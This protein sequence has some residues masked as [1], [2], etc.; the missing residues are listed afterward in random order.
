VRLN[1]GRVPAKML[2]AP[3][4]AR[5]IEEHP[6]INL[7][8][9]VDDSGS[10]IVSGRFDAG[11][12]I[13]SQVEQDMIAVRLT[14]EF[15]LVV[16]A[17]PAFLR[18]H[19]RPAEPG[20]V[21]NLPAIR[22]RLP[23][24]GTVHRWLFERGETRLKVA[25][26]GPL[27]VND[28]SLAVRAAVDGVGMIFLPEEW[29]QPYV[30]DSRLVTLLDDWAPRVPGFYLYYASSRQVPPP[31][32]AFIDFVHRNI[33]KVQDQQTRLANRKPARGSEASLPGDLM[34][35]LGTSR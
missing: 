17:S 13:G 35:A 2:V 18:Q 30:A 26:N 24:N 22:F 27:T 9:A 4:I 21:A 5:F 3:L 33:G 6:D 1:V 16:A 19:G 7:E 10:D 29:V 25:V 28:I 31:L 34:P 8:V 14:D 32:R 12:R 11:I 15:R 20:D 23:W